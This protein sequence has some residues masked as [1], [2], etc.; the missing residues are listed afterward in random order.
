MKGVIREWNLKSKDGRAV[1]VKYESHGLGTSVCPHLEFRGFATSS[2]GYR[3]H[4]F[5]KF[6]GT[7]VPNEKEVYKLAVQLIDEFY[8]PPMQELLF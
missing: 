7:E 6:G 4:F 2:T 1:K 3:S 5:G 8:T